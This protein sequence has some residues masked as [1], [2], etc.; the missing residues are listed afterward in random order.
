MVCVCRTAV[1]FEKR[2]TLEHTAQQS[3]V[4]LVRINV[5]EIASLKWLSFIPTWGKH[6][7][8][9]SFRGKEREHKFGIRDLTNTDHTI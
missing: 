2:R 7:N 4:L 9:L 5:S 8:V 3:S 6:K 1:P